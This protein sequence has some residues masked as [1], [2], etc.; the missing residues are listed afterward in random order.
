MLPFLTDYLFWVVL[1]GLLLV[2]ISSDKQLR[3]KVIGLP[4]NWLLPFLKDYTFYVVLILVFATSFQWIDAFA[5]DQYNF[6]DI[7]LASSLRTAGEKSATSEG[8][9]D[10]LVLLRACLTCGATFLWAWFLI[11]FYMWLQSLEFIT[12]RFLITDGLVEQALERFSLPPNL[13]EKLGFKDIWLNVL[14]NQ[15]VY[16]GLAGLCFFFFEKPAF[17]DAPAD[18]PTVIGSVVLF[19]IIFDVLIYFGHRI[20]HEY[21]YYWHRQHHSCKGLLPA[22]GWYMHIVDL[23]IELW[24]PIFVPPLLLQAN[25]LTCWTWLFLVEWDGVH[26]HSGMDFW[27]GVIPGPWRHWL[28]HTLYLCNYSPGLGDYFGDTE[29]QEREQDQKVVSKKLGGLSQDFIVECM[30]KDMK[31]LSQSKL[32]L[33]EPQEST[34]VLQRLRTGRFFEN[35]ME[36]RTS[37]YHGMYVDPN[38]PE[39]FNRNAFD[40]SASYER[41]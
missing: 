39:Y 11:F 18:L 6:G 19:M 3:D 21:I 37:F 35:D 12:K 23:F 32:A 17:A 31:S 27:P 4:Q 14:T 5:R 20:L 2:A 24:I 10:N 33:I 41:L 38:D 28:H 15:V 8:D 36:D 1:I 26:T 13:G 25:W 7:H 16:F 34:G 40:F 30:R 9:V 29:C 22:S